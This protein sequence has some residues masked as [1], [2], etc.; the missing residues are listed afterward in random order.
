M[1]T[2]AHKQV[3]GRRQCD[4]DGALPGVVAD[5]VGPDERHQHRAYRGAT[6]PAPVHVV[7]AQPQRELVDG[8]RRAHLEQ[9]GRHLDP[10]RAGR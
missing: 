3:Q 7:R 8:Q 2:S 10:R 9:H 4:G 5:R 1:A 6:L